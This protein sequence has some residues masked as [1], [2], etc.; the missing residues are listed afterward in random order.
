MSDGLDPT[1]M[2]GPAMNDVPPIERPAG[3]RPN[4]PA[5]RPPQIERRGPG[6]DDA[7][8][9]AIAAR[10]GLDPIMVSL[11]GARGIT[12]D[13][14][15]RRA[16]NPRLADLRPPERMGGFPAALEL[17]RWA[18]RRRVR[19]G[20]FGDYDV[21]GVTTAAIL[22]GYLEALGLQ[23]VTRVAHRDSGYGL[24]PGDVDAFAAA[25]VAVVLTGDTGTSDIESLE[26]LRLRGIKT[27]VIDHHQVPEVMPP[28]DALINPHQRGCE[29]PFKGLCSAGVAF[30]LCAALRTLLAG[31]GM[32]RPPDPRAWLD[33][34]AVATVCDMMPLV[35]ENRVLVR[36][37][38]DAL[39]R[40]P[41]PGLA[42]LLEQ[43]G[44]AGDA[45]DDQTVGFRIG[46]RL[47]APGRL[48]SAEPSL[49][50]LRARTRA[51]AMPIVEQI[52]ALNE[53]RRAL[54]SMAVQEALA[55]VAAD[56]R[57]IERAALVVAHPR[58]HPGVVGLAAGTLA[59]HHRRPAMVL[60]IDPEAGIARGSVRSFAGVDV[61]AALVSCAPLLE[62]FGG[63]RDA[64]G[65]SVRSDR[66]AELVEA[67]AEACAAQSP[68]AV[69]A[70]ETVDGELGLGELD[71][72]LVGRIA[73][74]GPWGTG[75][76]APRWLGRGRV[77]RVRVHKDRHLGLRLV[78]GRRG[79]E[80][81]CFD[82][83]HWLPALG[84]EV[85]FVFTPSL[86]VFRGERRVRV[87]I[88]A[89]WPAT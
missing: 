13:D 43:V 82:G 39:R 69:A 3:S 16:A 24:Q 6:R 67:F 87:V 81:I 61:R 35:D 14:A 25:G 48:G 23:T 37:G 7:E 65:L 84:E 64:A 54:S 49:R 68:G 4:G 66:I 32:A 60:A 22:S 80:G 28:C 40:A 70:V 53:R 83:A 59:E 42:A 89:L 55:L 30:Y 19:V 78:D 17:L 26:R 63:H 44:S 73:A 45:F 1:G 5:P 10:L 27:A 79:V 86:D 29:F 8:V 36:K 76:P 12:G 52:E 62:R 58:W 57:A 88:E 18:H 71:E 38:L 77:D 2:A 75:F 51:E 50:L 74:A 56:P 33:L 85:A 11:L 20:V 21:D 9:V 41:R 15:L 46:P 31:E 34:V 72:A 47:N